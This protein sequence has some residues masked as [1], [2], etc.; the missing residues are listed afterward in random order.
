[1]AFKRLIMR[2]TFPNSHTRAKPNFTAFNMYLH[3]HAVIMQ[4]ITLTTRRYE[5]HMPPDEHRMHAIGK[6][7]WFPL[8]CR[9][10]RDT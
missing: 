9:S 10:T 6:T 7:E 4:I 3:K 1:M 5:K 2:H 8:N